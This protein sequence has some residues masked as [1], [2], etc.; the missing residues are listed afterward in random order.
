M[1]EKE[2][3]MAQ[4]EFKPLSEREKKKMI[5]E[6]VAIIEKHKLVFFDHI[7][8]YYY[9]CRKTKAVHHKL[10]ESTEIKEALDANKAKAQGFQINKWLASDNATLQIAAFK[11]MAT[12][13]EREKLN[14]SS[15]DITSKGK[16]IKTEPL[17]IEVVTA[18]A[19][20]DRTEDAD[21]GIAAETE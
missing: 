12:D 11:L 1:H 13:E 4:G 18:A 2:V 14:Q 21:D 17:V 6:M 3:I 16:E 5:R 8:G 15:I 20:V 10:N 19:Q 9:G 7:F